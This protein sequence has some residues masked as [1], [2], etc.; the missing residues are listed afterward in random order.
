M[1]MEQAGFQTAMFGFRKTD[2][3][4][5]IDRM[6]AEN[7]AVQEAAAAT[8]KSLQDSLAEMRSE[9]EALVTEKAVLTGE[10][11]LLVDEKE[12]LCAETASLRCEIAQKDAD[13]LVVQESLVQQ[14]EIAEQA[15]VRAD[16]LAQE[17]KAAQTSARD[18]KGRLFTR[19]G[20][21]TVLRRDN[22][23]LTQTLSE[24]QAEI[25]RVTATAEAVQAESIVQIETARKEAS[26]EIAREMR[27]VALEQTVVRSSM[28]ESASDMVEDVALLKEALANLDQKIADSLLDLQ[29]STKSLAQALGTTEENMQNL[30][31]KLVQFPR[32]VEPVSTVPHKEK[33]VYKPTPKTA[34]FTYQ[35]KAKQ[36]SI[37]S[38]LLAQI[39]KMMGET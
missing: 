14:I 34:K 15:Q 28:K 33:P 6:S 21:A 8:A 39:S 38:L 32:K 12:A 26:D 13:L 27:R 30:G 23:R 31:V 22:T 7:L 4:A 5:C 37:S 19:E 2:V 11:Q 25:D 36:A 10:K 9:K 3:L 24:K 16:D 35:C 17:L 1:A 18:Y 29:R 20:E